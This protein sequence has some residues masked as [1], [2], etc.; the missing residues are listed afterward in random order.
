MLLDF[1]ERDVRCGFWAVAAVGRHEL[2]I[3]GFARTIRIPNRDV[4]V[5]RH[6]EGIGI[7]VKR[8]IQSALRVTCM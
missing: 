6:E 4:I 7:P 2:A 3:D 5:E 8:E 1:Q